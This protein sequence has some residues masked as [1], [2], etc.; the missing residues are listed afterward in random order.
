MMQHIVFL[1]YITIP[2]KHVLLYLVRKILV[3]EF[4]NGIPIMN[5]SNEIAKRGIDPGGKIAAM[6]KQ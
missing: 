3:M 4:I 5:L 6:A 1:H 2:I